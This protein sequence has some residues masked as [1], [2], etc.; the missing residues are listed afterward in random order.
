MR[1][2]LYILL[3]GVSFTLVQC[4]QEKKE[5]KVAE[6]IQNDEIKLYKVTTVP[7]EKNGGY[8]LKKQQ[9]KQG[10]R[11]VKITN[12][13]QFA[14]LFDP[15]QTLVDQ[16]NIDFSKSFVLAL[17]GI[18]STLETAFSIISLK[19]KEDFIELTYCLQEEEKELA[20]AIYPYTILV[21]DKKYNKD[22]RFLIE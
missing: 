13:A 18:P 2:I 17:V 4:K 6:K 15:N 9:P 7:Y 3:M 20:Q 11:H 12:Q 21:V 5:D 22:I 16:Q 14:N 8:V 1:R 10:V 19:E